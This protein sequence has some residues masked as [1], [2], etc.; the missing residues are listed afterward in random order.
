MTSISEEIRLQ[1][2]AAA[3][4]DAATAQDFQLFL[5]RTL[6]T[7]NPGGRYN[8]N[9]HI[10]AIA[11]HLHAAARG[12]I[13]RLVINLPPRMLKST[14][15]SVAWP[16][17]LL[18]KDARQRIMVA[19][20]A[21][22]LATKHST[23][24]RLVM[25]SDWYRRIFPDTRLSDAQNEKDCFATTR[26][27]QRLAVSVGGAAIGEGGNILIVDDPL[28]P[29]QA[30][31]AVWFDHTFAS[32]LDDKKTGAIVVVMQRLHPED[33]SGYLLAKGGEHL[34]LPAI[35][36]TMMTIARGSFS[37]TRSEGEA[38]HPAREDVALLKRTQSEMGS[39]NFAAQYQQAPQKLVGS[40]VKPWWFRR[41]D[42]GEFG[43]GAVVPPPDG[44]RDTQ[45]SFPFRVRGESPNPGT[46]R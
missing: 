15:V 12:E 31:H 20:Y 37:Y 46:R 21:Q 29:L 38:L 1:R 4:F 36:P 24:C 23:D 7:V 42:M 22:S 33:L 27:G 2:L 18:G 41:F 6:L 11:E 3:R 17:W 8:H 16:A 43:L 5:R 10:T 40:V 25:Q 34:C 9:W 32:R 13:T 28:N 45:R 19:S 30:S 35:A 26:R 14:M 39:A 44:G